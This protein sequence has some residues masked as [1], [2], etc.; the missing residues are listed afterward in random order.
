MSYKQK[1]RAQALKQRDMQRMQESQFK[2]D[3]IT[4][5][6]YEIHNRLMIEQ[7]KYYK[8]LKWYNKW[9]EK[10][11]NPF[12]LKKQK[13]RENQAAARAKEVELMQK[14]AAASLK[15]SK[16]ATTSGY[17]AVK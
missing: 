14:K 9:V 12:L 13:E 3:Q 1:Q 11:W 4:A 5:D 7:R 10:T 2:E 8:N 6:F 15:S 17:N 16:E